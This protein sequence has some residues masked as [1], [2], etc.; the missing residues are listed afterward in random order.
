MKMTLLCLKAKWF[1]MFK[2]RKISKNIYPTFRCVKLKDPIYFA[3]LRLF[4]V[5]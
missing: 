1:E 3:E 4:Y 5:L 2:V